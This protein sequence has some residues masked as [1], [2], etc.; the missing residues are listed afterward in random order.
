MLKKYNEWVESEISEMTQEAMTAK[1]D[2]KKS[3]AI[4]ILKLRKLK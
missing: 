4:W 1:N 2:G 3:A